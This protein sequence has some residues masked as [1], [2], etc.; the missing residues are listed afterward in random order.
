MSTFLKS[1]CIVLFALLLLFSCATVEKAPPSVKEA[2]VKETPAPEPDKPAP[3]ASKP[4]PTPQVVA[5][6][7]KEAP[8]LIAIPEGRPAGLSIEEEPNN[9]VEAANYID[10]GKAVTLSINPKGDADWFRVFVQEQGYIQ[11]QARD[12]PKG[13]GLDVKY[14]TYDEWDG[15]KTIRD[16]NRIPDG[17]FVTPGEYY[18]CIH[19]DYN[20][21]ASDKAFPVRISFL[22]EIDEG[23]PNNDPQTATSVTL[24]QTVY[25]AIYPR[26][27]QDWYTVEVKKQGYI[28]LISKE[29][30]KSVGLEARFCTYD[31]WD[32]LTVIRNWSRLPEGCAVM[33]GVY[34]F[35]L[36]DDYND[37]ASD[38][39]FPL[40]IDFIDEMDP[41]EHNNSPIDAQPFLPGET[42]TMAIYPTKDQDYYAVKL[43][44]AG[45]ISLQL[46][47]APRGIGL[48]ISLLTP[49]DDNPS[50]YE[51]IGGYKSMP[52]QYM[53]EAGRQYYIH[54]HDD[55]NDKSS[56]E[57]FQVRMKLE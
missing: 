16:W 26:G 28:R 17:C 13:L 7:K 18:I 40:L 30:P 14:Y 25:P 29:F 42:K 15:T 50:E 47:N 6:T 24:G 21:A 44:K 53:L 35:C 8:I 19:D 23:E 12:V 43:E 37:A 48:Q 36:G 5:P 32:G 10:F 4:E 27:D 56:L 31:E 51:R 1:T 22:P 20:D 11:I 46:Q 9:T 45:T 34:H 39:A 33:P 54:F 55:F 3:V 2:A 41:A 52:T 38:K 49:K 57:T